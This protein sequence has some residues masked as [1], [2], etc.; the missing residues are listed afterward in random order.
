MRTL[1]QSLQTISRRVGVYHRLQASCIYDLYWRIADRRL[2]EAR[3]RQVDFY[4]NLLDG[5]HRSDLIFD[6]G[7]NHGTK[8]DVFLRLGA[9]VIAVEPDELCQEILREKFQRYR[10]APKPVVIVGK[11]LSDSAAKTE[12]WIDGP[13]SALNTLSQKWAETLKADKGRFEDT[14]SAL[15]FSR[16][17]TVE[18][19][20]LEQLIVEHGQPFFVKIDVEGYE[21]CVLR[22][23]KR[24]VPFL[25]FEVNL[26]EFRPEGIECI[27]RLEGLATEGKFNYAPDCNRGLALGEWLDAQKFLPVLERCTEKS[28]EVFWKTRAPTER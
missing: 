25:S 8:V 6:I 10:L 19:T 18:T 13:G 15:D 11:A 26:P 16:H 17:K 28:I 24:A 21:V 2:I 14:H 3:S 7:A 22:G 9:R 4:R 20:T 23:L 27:K 12:M 1:K 5:F